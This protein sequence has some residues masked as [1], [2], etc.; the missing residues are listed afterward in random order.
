MKLC[1]TLY[2]V[3]DIKWL[4][5]FKNHYCVKGKC[6]IKLCDGRVNAEVQNYAI[7]RFVFLISDTFCLVQ[8][9][10]KSLSFINLLRH[11]FN[12]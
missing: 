9:I 5:S 2:V 1:D 6:A 12:K 8:I 11:N 7:E 10:R 3:I 4:W